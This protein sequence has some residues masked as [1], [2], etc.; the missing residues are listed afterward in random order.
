[1]VEKTASLV[2]ELGRNLNETLKKFE[3]QAEKEECG[4]C[5]PCGD[6]PADNG[7]PPAD[8]GCEEKTE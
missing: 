2:E 6:A 4:C 3:E 1:V 5:P 7:P 8:C